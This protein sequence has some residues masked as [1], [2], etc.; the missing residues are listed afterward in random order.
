METNYKSALKALVTIALLTFGLALPARA[1]TPDQQ[2][3]N[4]QTQTQT[5]IQPQ[6]VCGDCRGLPRCMK[7]S[8][9]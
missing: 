4:A 3:S 1:Q 7:K 9:C 2:N 8:W 5:Q 6:T